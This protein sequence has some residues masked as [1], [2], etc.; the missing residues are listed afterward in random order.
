L[1]IKKLSLILNESICIP[2][3]GTGRARMK[4]RNEGL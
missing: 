4:R 3:Y 1:E 2:V